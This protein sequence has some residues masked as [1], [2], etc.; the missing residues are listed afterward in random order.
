MRGLRSGDVC[1]FGTFGKISAPLS[2]V[3]GDKGR[4]TLTMMVTDSTE[5]GPRT[6]TRVASVP[7]SGQTL[8]LR[9]DMDFVRDEGRVA[10]SRDGRKWTGV[11]DHFPLKF[12]WRTGTFQG[13]QFAL[14]CYNARPD[15]GY[16]DIDSFTLS[17]LPEAVEEARP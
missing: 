8:W 3:G 7:V 10:Y 13:Q 17:P 6:E 12:D 16:I 1:G 4:R 14:S 2:I 15:G 11:G 5:D 9:T